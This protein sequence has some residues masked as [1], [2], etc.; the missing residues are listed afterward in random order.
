MSRISTGVFSGRSSKF[1]E[2]AATHS[3][4]PAPLNETLVSFARRDLRYYDGVADGVGGA[5]LAF[6]AF[7]HQ[8]HRYAWFS[9]WQMARDNSR[10]GRLDENPPNHHGCENRRSHQAKCLAIWHPISA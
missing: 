1:G 7:R 9:V 2:G 4:W 3:M 8:L 10:R 5:L 6:G